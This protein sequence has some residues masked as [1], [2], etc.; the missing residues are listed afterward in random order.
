MA[1]MEFTI[2]DEPVDYEDDHRSAPLVQPKSSLDKNFDLEM[3]Y[4][5][6]VEDNC[7]LDDECQELFNEMAIKPSIVETTA[8]TIDVQNVFKRMNESRPSKQITRQASTTSN[9]QRVAEGPFTS[10]SNLQDHLKILSE[11]NRILKTLSELAKEQLVSTDHLELLSVSEE[12]KL[13]KMLKEILR[14]IETGDPNFPLGQQ[15]MSRSPGTIFAL[16]RLRRKLELRSYKRDKHVR[17][18]DIDSYVNELI[19]REKASRRHEFKLSV[20]PSD[21][22]DND[23]IFDT[24]ILKTT[25]DG[26]GSSDCEIVAVKSVLDRFKSSFVTSHDHSTIGIV[27]S[28]VDDVKCILSPLTNLILKPYIRRDYGT[29]PKKL[30]LHDAIVNRNRVA[31]SIRY[32]I[33]YVHLRPE[34]VVPINLMCREHFWNGIDITECLDYPDYTLV[35]LYRKLIIGFAF[36]VP[37]MEIREYYLSFIFVHPDWRLSGRAKD[38]PSQCSPAH[39]MLYYL[40]QASG[41]FDITL[42]VSVSS[43]VVVLY[44][45][46]GFKIEEYIRNFYDKYY[47]D[48]HN[49][50]K[51]AFLMRLTKP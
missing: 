8:K 14:R 33:D 7:M 12:A 49:L 20:A 45:K 6:N 11:K 21:E 44:Q 36:L 41:S 31:N 13:L 23:V 40:I 1:R 32:P 27:Q 38:D 47:S 35:A 26:S 3:T 51:D 30:Q 5:R 28:R 37:N 43:P 42:H 22:N 16:I 25:G 50:S 24:E 46:F 34:H 17:I 9:I 18:F 10:K 48:E 15:L 29:T 4:L 2:K 39:Y 19:D